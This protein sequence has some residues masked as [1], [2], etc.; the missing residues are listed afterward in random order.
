MYIYIYKKKKIEKKKNQIRVF[1]Q[2][3]EASSMD[4]G[5]SFLS[6]IIPPKGLAI[7]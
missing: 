2:Q 6:I 5:L 7:R 1:T 4:K 3:R